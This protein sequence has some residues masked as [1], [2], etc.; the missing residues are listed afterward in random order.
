M[1]Q[2]F[3]NIYFSDYPAESPQ[4][5]N[6]T[7]AFGNKDSHIYDQVK[8]LSSF[9]LRELLGHHTFASL[10]QAAQ[11]EC[12]PFGTYCLR[13]LR[14]KLPG[15][16]E[17]KQ[18]YQL[19]LL[20]ESIRPFIEPI[21]ATF[22]GGET[23]PLHAWYPYL[24]G[25]SPRFVEQ[26]LQEFAPHATR[27]FDPFAGMGTTPLTV[28]RM[29]KNAFYCEL[30]P[31]L[32][33]LTDVKALALTLD[34]ISRK[35]ISTFLRSLAIRLE[36]FV[37]DAQPDFQLAQSY[38]QTFGESSFFD[39]ETYEKILRTRSAIDRL[40]CTEPLAA[41]FI[42]VAV[43]ANLIPAS[44]LIRRG[45]VR[46]KTEQELKR[47]Q[48]KLIPAVKDQLLLISSDLNKLNPIAQRPILVCED[49][50]ELSN[51][52]SL[53]IEAVIT[54]PPYLN[55]T[56]YFRN[57][58]VELWFLRCLRSPE[59]LSGFRYKAV[60][61]G[62]NDV[63][64]KKNNNDEI[65]HL[66]Q[67]VAQ[68]AVSAYDRRI[69]QM[70]SSYFSDMKAIFGALKNHLTDNA[71][72][73]IDIGDSS[74]G[75]VHVPTD[76][77][78]SKLL[79]SEGF[80]LER[81]IPLRK[82]MSRGGFPLKQA[83]LIFRYS[84]S[85]RRQAKEA[86]VSYIANWTSSWETFKAELPHQ[87]GDFARRNW[88]HPLHSLCSYQGKIKPSLASHLVKTF[89]S[90]GQALLDPF[91]G[92]G[93]IPFEAALQGITAWAFEINPAALHIAAAKLGQ[94][95]TQS[96][97]RCLN[98]L[99]AFIN[100][101]TITDEEMTSAEKIRFN[102]PLPTYFD[103]TTFR[104][105]LLARRYFLKH[106]PQTSSESLILA[107]L[108]HI[109]HGNRPYALS[110]RSH[111]ITPF[112]PTGPAEYRP[113]IPRLRDKVN[114]SLAVSY[115]DHFISGKAL[116][117]DATSW[118]PQA[119]DQLDAIITS[120]PFFDSTRFYLANWMRLWFCGWESEDFRT[121][122]LSFVDERQKVSFEIYEPIFRQARERLKPGGVMVLH[123]GK[124]RKC[125]MAQ[126]LSQVARRW[127]RVTDIFSENVEHCESHG[128][129]DKGAVTSHQ[130]LV[131]Q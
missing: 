81:E 112:A 52:P 103:T 110:R 55:G 84:R 51:L 13:L 39:P 113:L 85:H 74:Y 76:T 59:D 117:Q 24:E 123:L 107:S 101:Q 25:Y 57:T 40:S 96:C 87:R 99:E 33:Y 16:S 49:A 36:E 73:L 92:T 124:S 67:I 111:P 2:K 6:L 97:H 48:I 122:P 72:L 116:F 15:V 44:R 23:E 121:Q 82:R 56:N 14:Q 126:A 54:S 88:G 125:D 77:L 91:A 3:K 46:F 47:K 38:T 42:T 71:I 8:T 53:D 94:P 35:K 79:I 58:K 22:K 100:D 11:Q 37:A 26:A 31:L 18:P 63:T 62:I 68:L 43:L 108:L 10:Q 20:P 27:V 131:L 130:Y 89:L 34:E 29:E 65:A 61:A 109:L 64:V 128:I 69:P 95:D 17:P 28:A 50:R 19:S 9:E 75:N 127:F 104:E 83:L 21:Q 93:T 105:I 41:Q 4:K 90:S 98:F 5:R 120:P 32:Q 106:P 86:K 129:R 12:L 114:R 45:D 30:N 78:L 60:T 1:S 70:V 80:S 118:W 66:K 115:S 7:L 102:G 119:V